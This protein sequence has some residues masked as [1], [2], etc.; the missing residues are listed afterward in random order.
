MRQNVVTG[1]DVGTSAVRV[2][3]AIGAQDDVN[4]RVI[5]AVSRESH[6]LR[7]GYIVNIE[8]ATES[9]KEAIKAAEQAASVKI[10]RAFVSIGGM[11]LT[12]LNG[13]ASV[14]IPE[15][16]EV[17]ASDVD[18]A[19]KSAEEN[20]KRAENF[21]IIHVVPLSYKLDGK[22]VLG[23]PNGMMGKTLEVRALFVVCLEQHFKNMMNAVSAAG[24]DIE[25][26]VASPL[27]AGLVTLTKLQRM[28]GCVL[29]NIGAETVSIA[30]Y[31]NN[32][33][34]Y[35]HAFP[36]GSVDITN[37]I[38]LGF[39]I[40]IEDAEKVK[41]HRQDN[42]Y[43]KKKLDEIIMARLSDIFELIEAHLKK[44]GRNGLLPAG[45]VITGGGSSLEMIEALAKSSLKIPAKIATI[46]FPK[47]TETARSV[48]SSPS[49]PKSPFPVRDSSWAVA[50]G[51]CIIGLKTE[52]EEVMSL[53]TLKQTKNF[54]LE[55]LKQFLP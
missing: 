28:A 53:K 14:N 39:R 3:V 11:S 19:M 8:E 43:P 21:K 45:I 36:I 30:V 49:V 46:L 47:G 48:A 18:R 9:I 40:P 15:G 34:V 20:L 33:P 24:I 5:A 16:K 17:E 1:I 6:G 27:A 22:K 41:T 55:W 29:A 44:I 26:V 51:L 42:Q 38:A 10:G 13:E 25:D 23:K 7:H 2:V 54:I 50:Y 12:S 52:A 37:D 32:N 4:P 31:E 35:V